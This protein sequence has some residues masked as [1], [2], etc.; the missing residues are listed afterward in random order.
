MHF[1]TCYSFDVFVSF[2]PWTLDSSISDENRQAIESMLLE[3]QYPTVLHRQVHTNYK[4]WFLC[5]FSVLTFSY[6][7]LKVCDQSLKA[8]GCFS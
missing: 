3:E 5:V 7:C 4:C 2:Q 6:R 1:K 8:Y